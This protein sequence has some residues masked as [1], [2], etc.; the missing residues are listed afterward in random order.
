MRFL[1]DFCSIDV[2]MGFIVLSGV[3]DGKVCFGG[4]WDEIVCVKVG[5][6]GV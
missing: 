4:I 5:D 3:K 6:E 1:I 2:E